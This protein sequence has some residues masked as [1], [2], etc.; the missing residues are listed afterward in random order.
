M[1]FP[2][3]FNIRFANVRGGISDLSNNNGNFRSTR[4]SH[5]IKELEYGINNSAPS[6]FALLETKKKPSKNSIKLPHHLKFIGETSAGVNSDAGII[7][8]AHKKLESLIFKVI[9]PKHACFF[10]NKVG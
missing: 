4:I 2:F 7:L 3:P 5:K 6:F 1:S 8:Y 9:Y 10:T